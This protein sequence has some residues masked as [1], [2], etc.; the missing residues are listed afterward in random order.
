MQPFGDH[1]VV[2]PVRRQ[3]VLEELVDDRK[4]EHI[5]LKHIL[6]SVPHSSLAPQLHGITR[7]EKKQLTLGVTMITVWHGISSQS[8]FSNVRGSDAI[9]TILS[10]LSHFFLK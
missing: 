9:K 4:L 8:V 6:P 2:R 1:V 3:R 10:R 7:Y 5:H